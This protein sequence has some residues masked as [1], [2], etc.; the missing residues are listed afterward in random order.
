LVI[1][2]PNFDVI[3]AS[4]RRQTHIKITWT[5]RTNSVV[6]NHFTFIAPW[7]S[8]R[9]YDNLYM[10]NGFTSKNC[11]ATCS[12]Y[13]LRLR[14]PAFPAF[15]A[16]PSSLLFTVLQHCFLNSHHYR[17]VL[18][19]YH[20]LLYCYNGL[21]RYLW[22][23][24]AT[25]R[26]TVSKVSNFAIAGKVARNLASFV[27]TFTVKLH[28]PYTSNDCHVCTYINTYILYLITQVKVKAQPVRLMWTCS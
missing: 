15:L 25:L 1:P 26:S 9:C 27:H 21:Q 28:I 2:S 8:F 22:T 23:F 6:N 13:L 12:E 18:W 14:I 7:I 10:K 5:D 4:I 20:I 17:S 3:C 16:S 11:P 19:S 24:P